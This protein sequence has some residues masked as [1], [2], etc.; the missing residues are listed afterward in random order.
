L[1]PIKVGLVRAEAI[2]WI[3]RYA[4]D[5]GPAETVW[6]SSGGFGADLHVS[7]FYP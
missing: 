1:A 4:M 3:V 2:G 5:A 7:N 6:L